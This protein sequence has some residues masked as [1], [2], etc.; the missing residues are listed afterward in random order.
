MNLKGADWG[1]LQSASGQ[2]PPPGKSVVVVDQSKRGGSG[3]VQFG[4]GAAAAESHV[5]R[6]RTS[7]EI[8]QPSQRRCR[9]RRMAI[10]RI[11]RVRPHR[12]GRGRR[13][14]DSH[15]T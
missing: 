9:R 15:P 2:R 8:V 12:P 1:S 11:Y 13:A 10:V 3:R 4:I 14:G 5:S 6:V 7:V